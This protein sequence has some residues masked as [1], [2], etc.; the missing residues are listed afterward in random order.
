VN[1]LKERCCY[2]APKRSQ[3]S[4]E[5]D[6]SRPPETASFDMPDG[7]TIAIRNER[8][9]C[10]EALFEPSIIEAVVQ[11]TGAGVHEL[12]YNTIMQL[13]VD[14][15][16][17][18]YGNI[19]LSGGTTLFPGFADRLRT[20]ISALAPPSTQVKVID[21]P[22]R[23]YGAWLGGSTLATSSA[24]CYLWITKEEYDE[25]GPSIVHRKCF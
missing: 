19:V 9:R 2:V 6:L 10:P 11:T 18:M 25:Q 5:M 23:A 12:V 14:I 13:D 8:F 16:K 1:R 4:T 17:L 3:F 7:Q 20:E 15:R 22:Q 21:H 24:N